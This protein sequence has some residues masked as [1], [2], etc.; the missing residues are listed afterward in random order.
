VGAPGRN[1]PLIRFLISA[2]YLLVYIV[3]FPTYPFSVLFVTYLLPYLSFALIIDPLRF[4]TGCRNIHPFKGPL[5]GTTRV[6]RYQ[7]GKP[8]WI[9]QKQKTV[10][11]SG[12]SWATCKSVLRLRQ[13][14]T[15]A[16]PPLSFL[17]AGCPSCR[18]TNSVKALNVV[19]RRLNLAL[20]FLCFYVLQY[21]SFDW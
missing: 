13:I 20:V 1:A 16:P 2:L 15:P 19:K 6:S 18:P 11:G 10:S 12:I 4:Q 14:A 17:Q 9:L 5:S 21:I 8:I 3:G 7:K